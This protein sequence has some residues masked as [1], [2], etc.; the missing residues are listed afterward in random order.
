MTLNPSDVYVTVVPFLNLI[1]VLFPLA[2]RHQLYLVSPQRDP[3]PETLQTREALPQ[4]VPRVG[5]MQIFARAP[6]PASLKVITSSPIITL[7]YDEH[8]PRRFVKRNDPTDFVTVP[9]GNE[10][11]SESARGLWVKPR[12]G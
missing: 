2:L 10:S 8:S 9:P 12:V 7:C 1:V 4:I 5:V 3:L 6:D 11:S